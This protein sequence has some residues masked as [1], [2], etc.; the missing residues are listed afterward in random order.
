M[1]ATVTE[2]QTSTNFDEEV[3]T[4]AA[5]ATLWLGGVASR[6]VRTFFGEREARNV[7]LGGRL[8]S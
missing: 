6:K 2:P 3:R 7:S 1:M 4:G 5:G 8:R